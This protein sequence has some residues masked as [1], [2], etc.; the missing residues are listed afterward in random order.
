MRWLRYDFGYE[1]LWGYGHLIVAAIFAVLLALAISRRWRAWV[2]VLIAIPLGWSV[3][4]VWI[5]HGALDISSPLDLPTQRFLPNGTGR[6]LDAGAGSGRSSLMVLLSRPES[7][8]V[9]LDIFSEGY[10]IG[11]NTPERLLRN[12][13]VAGV[14]DRVEVHVGDMRKML[15]PDDSFDAAVSA[16]A[17]DHLPEP[18]IEEALRELRRTLKPGGQF[19]MLTVNPDLYIRLAFPLAAEHG[20]FGSRETSMLWLERFAAHGFEVVETGRVP[21]AL[22][23][24]TRSL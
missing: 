20:Y 16:F 22:Y 15:F 14:A 5:M 23:F 17:I 18:G 6:V 3:T 21:G 10:G 12:A 4:G 13:E 11:D 9:A 2:K 24:L 19:L 8:V 1:W 7:R